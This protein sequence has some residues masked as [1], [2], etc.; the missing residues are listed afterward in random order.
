[1]IFQNEASLKVLIDGLSNQLSALKSYQPLLGLC[2]ESDD[3]EI[4]HLLV[5]IFE[6]QMECQ[7]DELESGLRKLKELQKTCEMATWG[8]E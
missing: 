6:A 4:A 2:L 7:M 3:V 5:E 8:N 1:M